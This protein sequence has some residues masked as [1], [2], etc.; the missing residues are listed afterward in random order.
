MKIRSDV[1]EFIPQRPGMNSPARNPQKGAAPGSAGKISA[2]HNNAVT[3]RLNAEKALGEALSI[4]LMSQ[5]VLNRALEI[6]SR[7]RNIASEAFIQ[8]YVDTDELT[9][10]VGEI[11]MEMSSYAEYVPSPVQF[12]AVT[13]IGTALPNTED[14]INLIRQAALGM[15]E[16]EIPGMDVFDKIDAQIRTGLE[17]ADRTIA[18]ITKSL[19]AAY[20]HNE[21]NMSPSGLAG[22]TVTDIAGK[23]FTALEAQGNIHN[24]AVNRLL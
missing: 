9:Q 19:E 8:G 14:D 4:A 7:L 1:S 15:G 18:G 16:G 24:D 12:N 21:L 3:G 10:A 20:S 17:N 5:N 6:S 22:K 13:E 2:V 11:N 23:P